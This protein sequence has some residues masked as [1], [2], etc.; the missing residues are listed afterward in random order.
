M[1]Y[2]PRQLYAKAIVTEEDVEAF[3]VSKSQRP[4]DFLDSVTVSR[5]RKC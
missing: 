4:F 5:F 2:L 1:L 3:G